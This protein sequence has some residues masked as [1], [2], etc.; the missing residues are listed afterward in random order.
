[1]KTMMKM[2]MNRDSNRFYISFHFVVSFALAKFSSEQQQ[3]N[4][5]P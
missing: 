2:M 1:M 5:K 4:E 3:K